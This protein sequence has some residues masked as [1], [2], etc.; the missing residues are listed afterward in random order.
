MFYQIY[1][2]LK[3]YLL[4]NLLV[5]CFTFVLIEASASLANANNNL[6]SAQEEGIIKIFVFLTQIF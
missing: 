3:V 1:L 5:K 6:S 4:K 2:R